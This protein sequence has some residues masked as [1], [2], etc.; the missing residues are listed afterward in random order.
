M[1]RIG[2]ISDTHSLLRPEA[3]AFL[4][5]ADAIVHAG[6]IG[7]R[8]ILDT[9]ARIAPLTA[10]YGNNDHGPAPEPLP[11]LDWLDLGGG[12]QLCVIHELPRL[13]PGAAGADCRVV[14][15]GHS[16]KPAAVVRDGVLLV[17]PGSAGP[18]R[19]KL[20]VSA[21]EL[22]VAEDRISVRVVDLLSGELCAEALLP[23]PPA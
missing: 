5:G 21:G 2:L 7:D 6:D 19:F 18:R 20:P 10:V 11:E 22:L 13:P 3:E 14:V 12:R 4:Q 9:L 16:H 8:N 17:N 15:A 23:T 1:R